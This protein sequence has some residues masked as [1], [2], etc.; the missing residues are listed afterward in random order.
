MD[1]KREKTN[2][3]KK[4]KKTIIVLVSVILIAFLAG[5]LYFTVLKKSARQFYISSEAKNIKNTCEEVIE[6]YNRIMLD[7]EPYLN[8]RHT[9]RTELSARI[10]ADEGLVGSFLPFPGVVDIIENSKLVINTASDPEK[11]VSTSSLDLLVQKIPFLNISSYTDG[12]SLG[13]SIP[14]LIPEKHF[15]AR[16]NSVYDA[17]KKMNLVP[18]PVNTLKG[19]DLLNTLFFNSRDFSNTL[20][21]YWS[22]IA[23]FIEEEDVRY[24]ENVTISIDGREIRGKEVIV[25]FNSTKTEELLN[26]VV[27]KMASD[28]TLRQL[29]LDNYINMIG[30]F[31]QIGILQLIDYSQDTGKMNLNNDIN[32]F[33]DGIENEK[34]ADQLID[35]LKS[36]VKDNEF[37]EGFGMEL[38]IEKDGDILDRK[39]SLSCRDKNGINR[40]VNIHTGCNVTEG[41]NLK[42]RYINLQHVQLDPAGGEMW[43]S[44]TIDPD[45][46]KISENSGEKGTVEIA[47]KRGRDKTT[48]FAFICGLDIEKSKDKAAFKD[49][50]S[51]KYN[52]EFQGLDPSVKDRFTGELKTESWSNDKQKTR[53]SITGFTIDFDLPSMG[54]A[55]IGLVLDIRTEDRFETEEVTLPEVRQ[56]DIIDLDNASGSELEQIKNEALFAFSGFLT[57]L[58]GF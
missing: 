36:F 12:N 51:I 46:R 2:Q 33:L 41:I 55:D 24:G 13:F 35:R 9:T 1:N 53:N 42:N 17:F 16:K 21:D 31:K 34:S 32:A 7:Q 14:G 28:Q 37:P 15:I 39:A 40:Q 25:A 10:E 27:D 4:N 19:Q 30:L 3:D 26:A 52:I 11:D 6:L 8:S 23:S 20:N 47:Y 49:Y 44:F 54:V 43:K 5:G 50:S 58:I 45:I 22:L 38:V 56:E 48:E 29:T 57:R 18:V